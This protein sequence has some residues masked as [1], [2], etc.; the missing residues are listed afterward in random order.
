[1]KTKSTF[2]SIVSILVFVFFSL[3]AI[4]Q[5]A[6]WNGSVDNNW[7]NASNW[8]IL[9]VPDMSYDVIVPNS[10]SY[11]L[12]INNINSAKSMLIEAGA[13]VEFVISGSVAIVGN[14]NVYGTLKMTNGSATVF[15]NGHLFA[16][17]NLI[18]KDGA[19][20]ASNCICDTLSTVI[21]EHENPEIYAWDHGD[22][23]VQGSGIA[24]IT[25]TYTNP[26]ICDNLTLN[27]PLQIDENKA[28]E[29]QTEI[30]N[31]SGGEGIIINA[32]TTGTGALIHSAGDIESSVSLPGTGSK[33]N[34]WHYIS[35]PITSAPVSALNG[36][37]T[38]IWDQNETWGGVGDYTPWVQ[39]NSGYMQVTRGYASYT[40]PYSITFYGYLNYANYIMTMGNSNSGNADYQGWNLIGNPYAAPVDWDLVVADASFS[41]DIESAIYFMDDDDQT[42][43]TSNYRYYVA[44]TAGNYGIGTQD[45]TS[46]IPVCQG[47]FVK[48]NA[49]DATF[50]LKRNHRRFANNSFYK[51]C[52]QNPVIR[53][54]I[55]GNNNTDQLI[56]RVVENSTDGFDTQFDARK[57]FPDNDDIPMIFSTDFS[58]DPNMAIN[59]IPEINS[60]TSLFIGIKASAGTYTISLD[61]LTIKNTQ[62]AILIDHEAK[63]YVTLNNNSSYEFIYKGGINT[64]RFEIIFKEKNIFTNDNSI[65]NMTTPTAN[66]TTYPNPA[67][68]YLQINLNFNPDNTIA[69]LYTQTGVLVIT[70]EITDL[71]TT[72]NTSNLISGIYFLKIRSNN[73]QSIVKKIAVR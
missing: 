53:I 52:K 57:L 15:G 61:E 16:N 67:T 62:T 51:N 19:L 14:F 43:S 11:K 55:N 22:M 17:A 18:I 20:S 49:D 5:T 42:G 38:Y 12:I 6:T 8:D 31:N 32:G 45:A 23:V 58:N 21:Y 41:E 10:Y 46:I 40:N 25:G 33:S 50:L 26:T 27:I 56:F 36:D 4:S 73:R 71:E 48:S 24:T 66:I 29:V 3:S 7:Q 30:F 60:K 2:Y 13:E 9:S 68:D 63:S 1:M 28:L 47:F 44:T 65:T 59:S 39:V 54:S 72:I 69:E 35:S 37:V 70:Q 64:E 34:Q